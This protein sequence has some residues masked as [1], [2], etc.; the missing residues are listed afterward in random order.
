MTSFSEGVESYIE[1]DRALINTSI[2]AKIISYNPSSQKC[3]VI[4]LIDILLKDGRQKPNPILEDVPVMFPS[5]GLSAISFPLKPNDT[6]L[7]VFSQRSLDSWL[8]SPNTDQVNPEDFRKHD[9]TDA[10]AIPGL[11]SFPRAINDP[12]K[13][14]LVHETD[15]LVVAH[16]INTA[17]ESEVRIKDDGTIR[18]SSGESNTI[19]M[20]LN[21]DIAISTPG[22]MNITAVGDVNI[23]GANVNINP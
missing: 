13:H 11:F 9:Y 5:S 8:N 20:S 7:L 3:T 16:N 1:A 10:I 4:P 14:T 19:T 18:I 2:P 21:G 15:D 12:R 23:V 17:N 6:V 22:D